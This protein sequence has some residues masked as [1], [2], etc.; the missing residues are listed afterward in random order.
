M[1]RSRLRALVH[2]LSDDAYLVVGFLA[3]YTNLPYDEWAGDIPA[4]VRSEAAGLS[5]LAVGEP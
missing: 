4:D 3:Q 5:K 2:R 1:A